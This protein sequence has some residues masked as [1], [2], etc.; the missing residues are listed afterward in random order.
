MTYCK[1]CLVPATRPR[2]SFTD[3]VCNACLWAEEKK[4]IDWDERQEFF[5]A[6]AKKHPGKDYDCIVPWSGGKDSIYV[7]YKMRELGLEPL[8]VTLVPH[9]ET[10]IGRWNRINT[11]PDFGKVTLESNSEDYRH[12]AIEAFVGHGRPKHPFVT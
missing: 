2:V 10:D 8:L 3:G 5:V 7:A 1:K 11:C 12:F 4:L 9:L 6:N